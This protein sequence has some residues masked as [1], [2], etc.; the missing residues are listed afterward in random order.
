MP[1]TRSRAS[2]TYEEIKDLVTRRVAEEIEACEAAMNLKPLNESG[3]KQEGENEGN[4]NGGNGGNGNGENG[5]GNG[6]GGRNGNGN[7][8]GNHGMNY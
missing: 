8:N 4:K 7:I 3:V 5:N 2:M 6:N 1:N